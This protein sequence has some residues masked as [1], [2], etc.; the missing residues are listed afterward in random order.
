LLFNFSAG[1]AKQSYNWLL[2]NDVAFENTHFAF[3]KKNDTFIGKS[4]KSRHH[5]PK[6]GIRH[7]SEDK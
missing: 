2:P 7:L 4:G 3:E 1:K 5:S 6:W